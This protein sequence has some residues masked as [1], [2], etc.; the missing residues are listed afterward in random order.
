[1]LCQKQFMGVDK[2]IGQSSRERKSG[3]GGGGG[4]GYGSGGSDDLSWRR[5]FVSI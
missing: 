1:M 5:A 4:E 2:A 3:G